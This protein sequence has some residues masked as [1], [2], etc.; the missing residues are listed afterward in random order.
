MY[1]AVEDFKD[2]YWITDSRKNGIIKTFIDEA[3]SYFDWWKQLIIKELKWK[4]KILWK[5][6]IL[7][8]KNPINNV[9][10]IKLSTS[11]W[12]EKILTENQDYF[13]DWNFLHFNFTNYYFFMEITADVGFFIE[14]EVPSDIK[15]IV[16]ELAKS[17]LDSKDSQGG[18]VIKSKKIWS[19]SVQYDTDTSQKNR[20]LEN[21]E[22]IRSKY[23]VSSNFN[24]HV[25]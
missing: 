7:L 5:K 11:S 10:E 18:Q 17:F 12:E 4:Q 21:I 2:F 23:W 1:L 22:L 9:V 20:F 14:D 16:R 6:S 13:I 15:W 3:W 8:Q 25:L 24:L 19:F